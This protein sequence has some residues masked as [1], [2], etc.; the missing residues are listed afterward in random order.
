MSLRGVYTKKKL[1]RTTQNFPYDRFCVR[2][3][4]GPKAQFGIFRAN[5]PLGID[6]AYFLLSLVNSPLYSCSRNCT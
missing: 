1:C 2:T 5:R 6:L 4:I 3:A